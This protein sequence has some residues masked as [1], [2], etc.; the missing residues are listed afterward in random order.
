MN[1]PVKLFYTKLKKYNAILNLD[2]E[3]LKYNFI[4][5]LNPENQ[6]EA[7]RLEGDLPLEE[8]VERLAMIEDINKYRARYLH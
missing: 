2:K 6:L 3:R 8:L 7:D 4:R 1:D 5:G